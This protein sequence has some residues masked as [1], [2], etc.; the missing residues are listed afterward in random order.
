MAD[1][2][3]NMSFTRNLDISIDIGGSGGGRL[4]YYMGDYEVTPRKQRIVLPTKNTSMSDDLTVLQ[5]PYQEITN[6]QGGKTVVI[7]LE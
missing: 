2:D 1:I 7:G 6:P 3:F 5:V 4:P